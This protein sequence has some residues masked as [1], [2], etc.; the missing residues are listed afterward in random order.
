MNVVS[1]K[2]VIIRGQ[3]LSPSVQ[4]TPIRICGHCSLHAALQ[5]K[6]APPGGSE[7]PQAMNQD[8]CHPGGWCPHT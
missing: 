4:S 7:K 1:G 2:E 6:L 8:P 5:P 3:N